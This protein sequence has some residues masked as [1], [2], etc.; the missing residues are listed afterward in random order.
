MKG[1]YIMLKCSIC[2]LEFTDDQLTEYAAH[3]NKCAA[4][5]SLKRKTEDMRK[6]QEELE[7]IKKAKAEY[8]NLKNSFKD[9]YPSIYRMNF[10][11]CDCESNCNCANERTISNNAIDDSDNP[12][13]TGDLWFSPE[14]VKLLKWLG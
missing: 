3:V 8:E 12:I 2:G 11:N 1:K 9:K 10:D 14:F 6:I 7:E 13:T 5:E 4:D